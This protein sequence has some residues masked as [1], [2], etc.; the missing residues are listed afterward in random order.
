MY[1]PIECGR[2][3]LGNKVIKTTAKHLPTVAPCDTARLHRK[4]AVERFYTPTA[5]N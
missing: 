4:G 5:V 1:A 3:L 2:M